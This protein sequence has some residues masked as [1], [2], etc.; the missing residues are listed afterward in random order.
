MSRKCAECAFF[1]PIGDPEERGQCFAKPPIHVAL[2]KV[3]GPV[4]M[5]GGQ[6]TT[7]VIQHRPVVLAADRACR[8]FQPVTA[9]A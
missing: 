1:E 5:P 3:A 6:A 9:D 4:V 7:Q 8:Y 2:A